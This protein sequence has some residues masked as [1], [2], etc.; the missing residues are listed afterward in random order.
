M[1]RFIVKQLAR[2]SSSSIISLFHGCCA[3][4]SNLSAHCLP[5]KSSI[6]A[7][8]LIHCLLEVVGLSLLFIKK[9][10]NNSFSS[11]CGI[12]FFVML[13]LRAITHR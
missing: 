7:P 12:L 8:L 1:C 10:N 4:P 6:R 13:F 5:K 9:I 11:V 3:E 2:A